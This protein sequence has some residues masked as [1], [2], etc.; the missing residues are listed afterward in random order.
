MDQDYARYLSERTRNNYDVTAEDYT[1]TRAFIP[2]DLKQLGDYT[3]SGD[4]VLDLG[5]A[6][7]RLYEVLKDK[8][9]DFYGIDFSEKLIGIAQKLYPAGKFQAADALNVPFPDDCFDK[10]YSI[11]V[12]HNIPSKELQ[13]RYLNEARRVLKPGGLLILRV[14]DFWRR[15]EG[16]RLFLKYAFLKFFGK[17]QLD[18]FDVFIPWKSSEGKTMVQRYF[19]CFT[20][21]SIVDLTEKAGFKIKKVWR[22]G[23]DPRTNIYIVAEK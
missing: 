6:S 23:K 3:V 7:G 11:S 14:W 8:D 22:N 12:L 17:S 21:K 20:K 10:I 19:H 2:E 13:T 18:F 5:C 4:K 15:R 9:V 1:R 16:W